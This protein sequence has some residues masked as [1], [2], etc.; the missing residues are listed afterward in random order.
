MGEGKPLGWSPFIYGGIASIIAELGTFPLDTTKTR[1]Q[2]QGQKLDKKYA[3]LRYSGMT[4][5]L[6]QISRQE[7]IKSLYCGRLG[8]R[9]FTRAYSFHRWREQF[10]KI[11]IPHAFDGKNPGIL[12]LELDLVVENHTDFLSE[13]VGTNNYV[14][15]R[16]A[17]QY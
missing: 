6:V 14:E 4:D 10:C 12:S 2:I 11:L 3:T 13:A 16:S 17:Q 8:I 1:L 5:A 9:A 15:L 7:G